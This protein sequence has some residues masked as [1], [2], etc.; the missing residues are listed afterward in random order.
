MIGLGQ[1]VAVIGTLVHW[2]DVA[3]PYCVPRYALLS[4]LCLAWACAATPRR[5][6]LSPISLLYIFSLI[7]FSV[8]AFKS[9]CFIGKKMNYFTGVFPTT[10]VILCYHYSIGEKTEKIVNAFLASCAIVSLFAI[11]QHFGYC[12]PQGRFFQDRVYALIG[13]PVFLSAYM[14]F[15]IPLCFERH[16]ALI[17]LFLATAV[18]TQSRSGVLA[19]GIGFL[20]YGFARGFIGLKGGAFLSAVFLIGT[21]GMFSEVRNVGASDVGRYQMTRIA[22]K[23]IM[24]HPLGI[25]PERFAWAI[26]KYRDAEL[27]NSLSKYWTNSYTHNHLLE[28]AVTGGPIFLLIHAFTVLVIGLFLF[29]V[30]NPCLFGAAVALCAFGMMQPTP[31]ALKCV[32]AALVGSEDPSYAPFKRAQLVFVAG[33]ALSV[34]FSAMALTMAKIYVDGAAVGLADIVIGSYEYL[35]S[36]IGDQ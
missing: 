26:A 34:V 14:A 25:G 1:A 13:S 36:A 19:A 11:A 35:P 5:G 24:E 21:I 28:A 23:S 12:L 33:A 8:F 31:L 20:G 18:L 4:I 7:F 30:R 10:L 17:P 32:L 6:L 9:I 16:K 2:N 22:F 15:A 3:D 29:R 27:D